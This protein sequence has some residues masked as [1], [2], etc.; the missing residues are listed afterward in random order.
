MLEVRFHFKQLNFYGV[1][2]VCVGLSLRDKP[3]SVALW[4]YWARDFFLRQSKKYIC[5][6]NSNLVQ[7]LMASDDYLQQSLN[8]YI[9]ASIFA[10]G[11][12]SSEFK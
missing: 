6:L 5:A 12:D 3:V 9:F 8:H 2:P 1:V 4:R 10:Q 7:Q 11:S